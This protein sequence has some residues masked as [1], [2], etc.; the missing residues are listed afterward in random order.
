MY[1]SREE[2]IR[3]E[4]GTMGVIAPGGKRRQV[5]SGVYKRRKEAIRGDKR[6]AGKMRGIASGDKRRQVAS[7]VGV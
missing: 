2:V 3:E 6:R 7:R 4:T 5:A 1:K